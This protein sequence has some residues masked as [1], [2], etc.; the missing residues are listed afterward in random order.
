MEHAQG[1]EGRMTRLQQQA[2]EILA[3]SVRGTRILQAAPEMYAI[4]RR[5]ERRGVLGQDLDE[6]KALIARIDG[7]TK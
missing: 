3:R 7:D 6:I 1:P 2:D 5:V 4:L